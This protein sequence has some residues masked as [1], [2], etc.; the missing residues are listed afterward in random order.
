LEQ[1]NRELSL[2]LEAT[3]A[4]NLDLQQKCAAQARAVFKGDGGAKVL[5]GDFVNHYHPKAN[6][7][8]MSIS[9]VGSKPPSA[10]RTLVD[11]FEGKTYADYYWINVEGKRFDEVKPTACSVTRL[12]G[13]VVRCHSIEEY[14]MLVKEFLE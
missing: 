3:R 5:G 7:C 10:S 4:G 13:E 14:E 1:A 2:K 8:F 9:S 12:N 6:K 11:A